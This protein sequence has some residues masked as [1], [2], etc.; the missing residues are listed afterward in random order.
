ML[1]L[2]PTQVK[3]CYVNHE[4]KIQN[5]VR[6]YGRAFRLLASYQ[7]A[8]IKNALVH[9]RSCLDSNLLSIIVRDP[10]GYTVWLQSAER[11]GETV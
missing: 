4:G 3:P 5:G 2:E 11:V 9:C 6:I 1:V 10:A 8:Q 7:P